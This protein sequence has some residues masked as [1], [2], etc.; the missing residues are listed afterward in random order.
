MGITRGIRS[1]KRY[2]YALLFDSYVAQVAEVSV[3][4][5][6]GVHVHKVVCAVDC[7]RV[8][9]PDSVMAQMQGGIVFGLSAALKDEI[10]FENGR[11]QQ[12]NFHNYHDAAHE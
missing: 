7:G 3:D 12:G 10:T 2:R 11:V 1:R 9:N 4:K 5:D 6:G 8:I